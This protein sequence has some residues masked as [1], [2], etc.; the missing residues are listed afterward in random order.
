MN[1]FLIRS[2][3]TWIFNKIRTKRQLDNKLV[4]RHDEKKIAFSTLALV[5]FSS[6]A[7]EIIKIKLKIVLGEQKQKNKTNFILHKIS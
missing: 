3:Q 1:N 6:M 2:F 5:F 7:N 4:D